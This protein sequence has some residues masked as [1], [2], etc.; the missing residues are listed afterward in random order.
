MAKKKNNKKSKNIK[1]PKISFKALFLFFLAIIGCIL[2]LP[3]AILFIVGMLPTFVSYITDTQTGK[4]KTFTIGAINFS[5]CFY[6]LVHIWNTSHPMDVAMNYLSNPMTIVVIYSAAGLGYVINYVATVIVSSILRQKG[7]L[8]LE[9][10]EERKRKLEE[11]WGEKVNGERPLDGQ[12]FL[13]ENP[14]NLEESA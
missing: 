6:Y 14:D 12:G 13:L 2:Y 5:G 11:R 3:T 7:L 8:R 4:N 9:K 1:K 10:I